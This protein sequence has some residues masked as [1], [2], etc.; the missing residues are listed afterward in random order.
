MVYWINSMYKSGCS[1]GEQYSQWLFSR[2]LLWTQDRRGRGNKG[3]FGR[4]TEHRKTKVE[5]GRAHQDYRF[6]TDGSGDVLVHGQYTYCAR[7]AK[8]FQF[9]Y[10]Q[11]RNCAARIPISTHIH[12]SV[13]NLYC[14]FPPSVYL[15][16]CSRKGRPIRV[17]YNRL[18]KHECRNWECTVPFLGI[19]VLNF[20][21]ASL[22]WVH[23]VAL[24]DR[25]CV[26]DAICSRGVTLFS[27]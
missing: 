14:I 23:F 8:K 22:L 21:I 5:S 13:S 1:A 20:G 18:Q 26:V 17:I 15:F 11:K 4:N 7:T 2:V 24:R 10:S 3:G 9:T 16:S 27:A 19:F 25:R 6:R 12:G